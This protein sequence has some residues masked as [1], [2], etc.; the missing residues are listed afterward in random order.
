MR[1]SAST[2]AFEA[3]DVSKAVGA[4]FPAF[5]AAAASFETLS[6]F[7]GDGAITLPVNASN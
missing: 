3:A 2:V 5:V 7:G 4:A 6:E 1:C